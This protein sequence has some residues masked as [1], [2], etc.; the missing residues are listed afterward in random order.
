MAPSDDV[1]VLKKRIMFVTCRL[2]TPV[3]LTLYHGNMKRRHKYVTYKNGFYR[4]CKLGESALDDK[5][6][7]QLAVNMIVHVISRCTDVNLL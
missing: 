6:E 2:R 5:L 4:F 1:K 3:R 7:L